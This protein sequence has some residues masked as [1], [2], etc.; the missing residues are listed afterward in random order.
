MGHLYDHLMRRRIFTLILNNN[1][2]ISSGNYEENGYG[3]YLDLLI[4]LH[5]LCVSYPSRSGC[6]AKSFCLG[7]AYLGLNGVLLCRREHEVHH[8][9]GG[10]E[11]GAEIHDR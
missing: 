8:G 3:Q 11:R 4:I 6:R 7:A 2:H 10:S 9:H 1:S 5:K